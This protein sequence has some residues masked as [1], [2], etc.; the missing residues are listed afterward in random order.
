MSSAVVTPGLTAEL[1]F[2][3]LTDCLDVWHT[4]GAVS[5]R[6]LCAVQLVVTR[7]DS[8]VLGEYVHVL[9]EREQ[10]LWNSMCRLALA[11]SA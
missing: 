3:C 8:Q 2:D 1:T 4:T 5:G 10:L 7:A 11:S 9:A 6:R